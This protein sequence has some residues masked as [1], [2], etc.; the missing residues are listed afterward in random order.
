MRLVP[1]LAVASAV[2]LSGCTTLRPMPLAE[3]RGLYLQDAAPPGLG[4]PTRITGCPA[5]PSRPAPRTG[6][7]KT[8]P[9]QGKSVVPNPEK[10]EVAVVPATPEGGYCAGQILHGYINAYTRRANELYELHATQSEA[11]LAGGFLGTAGGILEK[12][13]LAIF[14]GAL[15]AGSGGVSQ[16]Y[17]TLVQANNYEGAAKALSCMA[18]VVAYAKADAEIDF[19]ALN[20]HINAVRAKLRAN[21]SKIDI[22]KTDTDALEQ[23][24]RRYVEL[25]GSAS[26]QAKEADAAK[27][28]IAALEKTL[29]E[30]AEELAALKQVK[31]EAQAEADDLANQAKDE[32]NVSR[33]AVEK[34]EQLRAL[35]L[36]MKSLAPLGPDGNPV[37]G[38][39]SHDK[40]KKAEA[41]ARAA[42]ASAKQAGVRA[43]DAEQLALGA[44]D[45]VRLAAIAEKTLQA[46]RLRVIGEL[47]KV[48]A[49]H[50]IAVTVAHDELQ[51]RNN[52]AFE[53]C[54][55]LF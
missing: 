18:D 8:P 35:A 17:A 13:P 26:Q 45:V 34:A 12:T 42:E 23:A 9:G 27:E 50:A 41:D 14:G 30:Q 55:A 43:E 4:Y 6:R 28:K 7:P 15:A 49:E 31:E 32:G 51:T 48:K 46:T 47:D 22:A 54:A 10:A 16:A 5:L 20:G 36:K 19:P 33:G 44:Q 21:Q 53:K 25:E 38:A 11:K 52:A 37:V 39:G 40:V 29:A 2:A 24:I 1:L 3:P